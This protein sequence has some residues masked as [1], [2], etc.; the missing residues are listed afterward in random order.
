MI[1]IIVAGSRNATEMDVRAAINACAWIGFASA[2]VSG[3]AR[4]ADSFGERWAQENNIDIIRFPAEWDK[5]GRRAG[6]IRNKVMAENAQ[7]L[8]AVWDGKSKGTYSMI[9]LAT[10][11]GLRIMVFRTDTK[12]IDDRPPA[13]AFVD[14]WEFLEERAAVKE[15]DAGMPRLDAERE[16]LTDALRHFGIGK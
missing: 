7:G 10:K 11:H 15:Y 13:G 6:Y 12:I 2:I 14:I 1:S 3:T 16:A 4:G 5:Y 9:D 8:L